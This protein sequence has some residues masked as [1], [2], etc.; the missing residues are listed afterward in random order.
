MVNTNK[1][2]IGRVAQL[3]F[4]KLTFVVKV[5]DVRQVWGKLQAQV[6]PYEGGYGQQWVELARLRFAETSLP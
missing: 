1:D 4:D 5:L 2:Y 6:E 3:Q